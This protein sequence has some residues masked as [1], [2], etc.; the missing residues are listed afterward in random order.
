MVVGVLVLCL[1]GFFLLL[2]VL[3]HEVLWDPFISTKKNIKERHPDIVWRQPEKIYIIEV[4]TPAD[5][6]ALAMYAKKQG[7]YDELRD[8][9]AAKNKK[10]TRVIPIVIGATGAIPR[11][12]VVNLKELAVDL[13]REIEQIQKM[14]AKETIKI[15]KSV[16]C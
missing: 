14:I 16:V 15:V 6:N 1:L 2:R 4:S 9:E 3:V 10:R 8:S 11:A 7:K 13:E 5:E 12:T